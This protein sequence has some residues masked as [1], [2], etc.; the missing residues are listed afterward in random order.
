M[1]GVINLPFEKGSHVPEVRTGEM[2]TV[3]RSRKYFAEL[4]EANVGIFHGFW[5]TPEW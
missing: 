4:F 1:G 2:Q 5:P 3:D